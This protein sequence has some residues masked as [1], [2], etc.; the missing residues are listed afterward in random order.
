MP[1]LAAVPAP[2]LL[3]PALLD[4][5][6]FNGVLADAARSCGI[7]DQQIAEAIHVCAPYFS[8]LMRGVA[9]QWARRIVALCRVTGSLGPV[10]W[11][12]HQLGCDVVPRDSRAAEVAE[13]RARLRELEA[14]GLAA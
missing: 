10:Q 11:M 5:M 9:Q 7:D 12:A 1:F 6:S 14:G 3:E 4:R 2:R 13:L 8:R